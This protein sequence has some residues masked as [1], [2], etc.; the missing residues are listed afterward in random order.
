MQI[1]AGGSAGFVE[2]CIMHPLDLV[3]TRFQLQ[4]RGDAVYYTSIAD[5]FKKMY[6]SE[7]LLSFYKGL[8]PPILVETP[9]RATKFFTF[10]QYKGLLT[11]GNKPA[12]PLIYSLAGLGA[13]I[14]EAL[15]ICPFEVVK[16]TLQANKDKPGQVPSTWTVTRA[17]VRAHG[18]RGLFNG[19]VP[20][21]YR[22]SVF[23]TTYFGFFHSMK[24]YLPPSQDTRLVLLM[25]FGV[26]LVAGVLG[27]AVNV[28]FDVV[29]SRIQGPQPVP[30]QVKYSTTFGSIHT[31]YREEGFRALFKGLVPKMLRLGPGGG[32]LLILFDHVYSYLQKTFPD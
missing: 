28:P 25:Q 19:L 27:C 13:G 12:T 10:E 17:V 29:K 14:S 16:I 31:V 9:K 32:I 3:K 30:G 6:Q 24:V 4:T 21:L 22:Q 26:G 2:V 18:V 7:G 8:L 5:C 15:V 11:A 20:T 23:N 1:T